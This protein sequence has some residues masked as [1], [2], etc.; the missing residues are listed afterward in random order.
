LAPDPETIQSAKLL[1]ANGFT[2]VHVLTGGIWNIRARAANQ[3]GLARLMKWV[4]DI[5]ADNL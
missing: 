2:K 1:A 5:P 3:K 4:V